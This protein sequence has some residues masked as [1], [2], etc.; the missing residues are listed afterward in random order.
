MKVN[1]EKLVFGGQGLGRLDDGRVCF[2]W[3]ALPGEEVELEILKNKKTHLEAVATRII[4]PSPER[5]EPK[6]SHFLSCSPWQIMNFEAENKW[7]REIAVETYKKLG[8]IDAGDLEIVSD[9]KEYGYRNKMEYSFVEFG[10]KI[11]LGF[12]IRESRRYIPITVCEL[13]RPEINEVAL[14]LL[15]WINQNQIP[16]RSL[17]TMI[18]RCNQK[19]EV[20]AGLFLKDRLQFEHYPELKNNFVGLTVFYSTHKSPASVPTDIL[21]QAGLD[22][23]EEDLFGIKLKYGLFSFFQINVPVFE[24]VLGDIEKFAFGDEGTGRDLSVLDFYSGV[25]SISLPLAGKFKDCVLVDNNEEAIGFAKENIEAVERDLTLSLSYKERGRNT[26]IC[27]A[28]EKMIEL[29]A[30]DKVVIVDP[31]RAGLDKR[32]VE[33]ILAIK[34]K[35]VIYLS[36]NLSTHARDLGILKELYDIK[37]MKL[38][39]FFPRTAHIEGL[40]VLIRR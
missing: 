17:K 39:N 37:F 20:L 24:R 29:I 2:V 22:Y 34:P 15:E 16:I 35:Q 32:V 27:V 10:R 21:Y 30:S 7:K 11:S 3:N 33:R 23:L 8:G 1:I 38:Y 5:I 9:E 18:V 6:E 13:A 19:G 26:V 14:Q 4:K 12:H 40:A 25:G 31:P 28:A 36:C